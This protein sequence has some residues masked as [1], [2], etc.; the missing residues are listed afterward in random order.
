M[1]I[2]R[3]LA[4]LAASGI[5]TIS[6]AANAAAQ[7]PLYF[8]LPPGTSAT[9]V[10]IVNNEAV[11]VGTDSTGVFKWTPSLGIVYLGA[12]TSGGNIRIS[13]DGL[14]VST[15]TTSPIDGVQRAS[16][17]SGGTTWTQIP[18][19]A[20]I[21]GTMETSA[22]G[23]SGDGSTIVGLGWATP[24][25]GHCFSWTAAGGTI[26]RGG[27]FS[28]PSSNGYSANGDGS[29]IVGWKNSL[30]NQRRAARWVNGALTFLDYVDPSMATFQLSEAQNTNASGTTV[31]GF[32]VWGGDNSAWRWDAST[33]NA[34]LLPNLPN[35]TTSAVAL[36]VS[37]D[38]AVVVGHS[39]GNVIG[40][41]HSILWLNGQPQGL[42]TYLVNHNTP[43]LPGYTDLG[44]VTAISADGNAIVGRG[45]GF[46]L[47]QPTGGWLVLLDGALNVGTKFC[48]GDGSGT[49]CPCGNAG[50][51]D[52]GCA[53]SVNAQGA[54][55][56]GSGTASLS[57][58]SLDLEGTGMPNSSALFFQGTVRVSNGA[59]SLFGD[60]LRCAGGS[61]VRLK[62]LTNV[63]GTSHYPGAGNPSVSVKGAVTSP[64]LRT[65]QVWYRN[66]AAFCTPSTF[67]LTNGLEITWGA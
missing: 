8:D 62:A 28:D 11:V 47:G 52:H 55:L 34:T 43:N 48:S 39:G 16:Y 61:I 7:T 12:V 10:A 67:N 38:G 65:Y 13:D 35:E 19:L 2:P 5:A 58:D 9:G 30:A 6:L 32:R 63:A 3:T 46:G 27:Q 21:S 66:A 51:V 59:G 26:D 25:A 22:N 57:A 45:T 42:Y 53:S 17:W 4:L 18:G 20:S 31:V 37:D 44:L 29:V 36:D 64:G 15:T 56:R 14:R 23:L 50:L 54:Q 1:N 33:G 24:G 40:G 49:A 60:G 41:T